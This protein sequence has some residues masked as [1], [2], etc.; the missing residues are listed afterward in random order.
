MR[1]MMADP[2][3]MADLAPVRNAQ[4]TDAVMTRHAGYRDRGLGFFTVE[5]LD[6]E[7]YVGF[8]G[9]KPGDAGT[10]AADGIEAGWCVAAE[11]WRQGYAL[12][13]MIAVL[14]WG[15]ASF[16]VLRIVAITPARN[17]PSQALMRRLGMSK[18]PDG[19]FDSLW[20]AEG[21]PL[22]PSVAYAIER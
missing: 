7:G 16:A 4:E 2:R 6:D 14:D 20:F 22:R 17:T 13:A 12:E 8:C 15:W 10:P 19:D 18:L 5:R 3:V 1:A 21:H 11:H 9:L